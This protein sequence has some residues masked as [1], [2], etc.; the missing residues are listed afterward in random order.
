MKT[1]YGGLMYGIAAAIFLKSI[2][3]PDTGKIVYLA[4]VV[5]GGSLGFYAQKHLI[6]RSKKE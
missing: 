6:N 3:L 1:E 4:A 5:I 2:L